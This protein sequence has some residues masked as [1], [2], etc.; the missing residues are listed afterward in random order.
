[1]PNDGHRR[2]LLIVEDDPGIRAAVIGVL[3]GKGYEIV[4]A[5]NGLEGP[6]LLAH[7]AQP[8]IVLL[9]KTM[10]IMDGAE[11]LTRLRADPEL[12]NR[13]VVLMKVREGM[14]THNTLTA[15]EATIRITHEASKQITTPEHVALLKA[16]LEE[17][18]QTLPL[19]GRIDRR[20]ERAKPGVYLFEVKFSFRTKEELEAFGDRWGR[21]R[22]ENLPKSMPRYYSTRAEKHYKRLEAGMFIPF[23]LGK[24]QNVDD[25][26]YGHIHGVE[27]SSTSSLKLLSRLALLENCEIRCGAVTLDIDEG[28]Y[29]SIALIESALRLELHPIIGSGRS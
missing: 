26:I 29:F 19:N 13:T 24:E 27:D 1:M 28:A 8:C 25:R 16:K 3:Q 20:P 11:F 18:M 4:A 12:R 5:S 23:Y 2:P 17:S 6:N 9:N 10:P 14:R 22:A 21:H 7:M 15:I